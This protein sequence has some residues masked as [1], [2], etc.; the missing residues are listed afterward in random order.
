MPCTVQYTSTRAQIKYS[1]MFVTTAAHSSTI[2]SYQQVETAQ[3][4]RKILTLQDSLGAKAMW[5]K[6]LKEYCVVVVVVSKS[7]VDK[8]L[9]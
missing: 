2:V 3:L 5:K 8:I 6:K 4:L 1:H 9:V 7:E